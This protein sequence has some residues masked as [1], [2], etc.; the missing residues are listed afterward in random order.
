MLIKMCHLRDELF[1]FAFAPNL[2]EVWDL[3][4]YSVKKSLQFEENDEI[5]DMDFFKDESTV[6]VS[7]RSYSFVK[8]NMVAGSYHLL[9]HNSQLN[10]TQIF[11]LKED[12]I[13]RNLADP[14]FVII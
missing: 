8:V 2:I 4:D 6:I 11:F 12:A 7:L 13:L 14:S 9:P 1:I 10:A 5:S 3:G